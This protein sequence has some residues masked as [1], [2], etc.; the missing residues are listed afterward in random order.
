M[1]T[2]P[3]A[4]PH[5]CLIAHFRWKACSCVLLCKP[6]VHVCAFLQAARI[7]H[8]GSGTDPSL[9]PLEAQADMYMDTTINLFLPC[10]VWPTMYLSN[11]GLP[12]ETSALTLRYSNSLVYSMYMR[13]KWYCK[14]LLLNLFDSSLVWCFTGS[15]TALTWYWAWPVD[16]DFHLLC[17]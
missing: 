10:T 5:K 9:D 13:I 11:C 17:H 16:L 1:N 8:A 14:P 3:L 2:L 7:T 6:P 15:L 12:S 4:S